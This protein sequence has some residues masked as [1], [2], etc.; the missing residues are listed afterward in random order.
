MNLLYKFHKNSSRMHCIF[1]IFAS[2][3]GLGI[4][5]FSCYWNLQGRFPWQL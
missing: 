3:G 1:N 4:S 5:D 2:A